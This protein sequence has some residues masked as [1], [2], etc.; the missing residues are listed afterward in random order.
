MEGNPFYLEEAINAFI[1]SE[2][3]VREDGSWELTRSLLEANIPSTVQGIIS[4][5]LDR[6]EK[7]T[8]R[9]LQEASVIGRAFLYEILKRIS[10]LRAS[11]KRSLT[12]LERLDLIR[13]KS[14]Q[15]DI[16]Y[17]FKHALTQ[18]AVYNGILKKERHNIHERIGLVIEGLFSDRLPEFYETLA[19][20]FKQGHSTVKAIDYL[21]KAGQK[22]L[23][24]YALDE[25]DQYFREGFDL[26]A[27]KND[28]TVE[29]NR[30]LV[31][32]LLKWMLVFYYQGN[33][34]EMT[35]LLTAYQELVESLNDR[36]QI[37]IYCMDGDGADAEGKFQGF[38]LLLESGS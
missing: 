9:I 12:S 32:I 8:K 37:G 25:S 10:E 2:T 13:L 33:F 31:D 7:E 11:I 38:L 36:A 3:L 6:L 16:E 22:S 30:L 23:R 14:L 24:R 18:E 34:K 20:H 1:E 29:D 4:A 28:R 17:I 35:R 21:I 26:L 19:F 15:P 5:R 27:M